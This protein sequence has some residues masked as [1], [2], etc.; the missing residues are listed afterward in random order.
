M[1][2]RFRCGGYD[3]GKTPRK[4]GFFMRVTGAAGMRTRCTCMIC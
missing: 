1:R 3:I 4:A 2:R